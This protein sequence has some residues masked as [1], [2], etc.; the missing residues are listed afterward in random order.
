M[1]K[2]TLEKLADLARLNIQPEEYAELET[3]INGIIS[4][5]DTVQHVSIEKK[6]SGAAGTQINVARAD[7]VESY[8]DPKI[9]VQASSGND[10]E[11]IK[12]PKVL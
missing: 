8:T 12:V 1:E 5:V 2:Q 3:Q 4:L 9:L 7:T 11:F 10:G 6:D